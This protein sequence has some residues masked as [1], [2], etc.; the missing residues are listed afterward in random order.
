MVGGAAAN[1]I[2]AAHIFDGF[3]IQAQLAQINAAILDA[4]AEGIPHSGGL[5]VDLLHHKVLVTAFFGGFGVP[6]DGAGF[7]FNRF[8]INVEKLNTV[9]GQA[10]DFQVINVIH[11]AGIFQQSRN[12]RCD[13]AAVFGLADNQRAVFPHCVYHAGLVCKQDAQRIRTTH[14]HH[15]A[16]DGIQAVPR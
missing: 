8:F 9:R 15:H 14:M 1:D 16:G 13:Q 10:G 5:F 12:V 4:G 6:L 7:F 11:R 3:F 2:D